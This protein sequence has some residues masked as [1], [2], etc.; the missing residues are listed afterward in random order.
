MKILVIENDKGLIDTYREFFDLC[1]HEY[2]IAANK[3]AATLLF[4][5]FKCD[6]IIA[7]LPLPDFDCRRFV[8]N[9]ADS[10]IDKNRVIVMSNKGFNENDRRI[11]NEIG[12]VPIF[13]SELP[14]K[15]FEKD[16]ADMK[17]FAITQK[18]IGDYEQF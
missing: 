3:E 11:L 1:G 6:I 2:E 18:I 4:L 9:L 13:K 10:R 15:L 5:S 7:D 14:L 8:L 12:I 17:K 16:I